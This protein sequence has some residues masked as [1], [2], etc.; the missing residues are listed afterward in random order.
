MAQTFQANNSSVTDI[1]GGPNMS[2]QDYSQLIQRFE[3]DMVNLK[4]GAKDYNNQVLKLRQAL[5]DHDDTLKKEHQILFKNQKELLSSVT[6]YND[7]LV[8]RESL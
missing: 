7:I 8:G 6:N 5:M 3:E 1:T 4:K 2:K